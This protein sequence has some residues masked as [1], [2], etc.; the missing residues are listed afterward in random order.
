MEKINRHVIIVAILVILAGIGYWW[1]SANQRTA[2]DYNDVRHGLERIEK[3]MDST[4]N[5][6]DASQAEI[7]NA[8]S[9]LCGAAKV[10]GDVESKTRQNREIISEIG[11]IIDRCK[12]R[13]DRIEVIIERVECGN[14]GNGTQANGNT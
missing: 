13:S 8:Q 2:A 1:H 14:Q 6:L 3:R 4:E 9:E 7:Q 11:T 10:V 5:R 12:E